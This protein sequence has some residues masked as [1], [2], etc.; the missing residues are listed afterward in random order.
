ME[1]EFLSPRILMFFR[2]Q[3]IIE[4]FLETIHRFIVFPIIYIGLEILNASEGLCSKVPITI[5]SYFDLLTIVNVKPSCL[6]N[7]KPN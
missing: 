7:P 3:W 5:N 4:I 6:L 1:T 2:I